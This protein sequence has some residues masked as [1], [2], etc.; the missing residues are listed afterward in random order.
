MLTAMFPDARHSMYQRRELRSLTGARCATGRR[1]TGCR[2]TA[3]ARVAALRVFN[4]FAAGRST[5]NAIT[6]V[7]TC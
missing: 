2:R 3:D 4:A 5:I 6:T 7:V 1:A